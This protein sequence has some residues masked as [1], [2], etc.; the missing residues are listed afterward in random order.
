MKKTLSNLFT[1]P[2]IPSIAGHRFKL[3]NIESDRVMIALLIFQWFI[4]TF[5]TSI[6][7]DT[8]Y[9][10][11]FGSALIVLPIIFLYPYLKGQRYYRYFIAIAMMLFS[12]IFIQQ[13]LG[14]IEMHFHIFIA[15]A[16]LTLYKDVMPLI[17]AA[18]TTI[19]HHIVFNYLQFYE[20]SLFDMPVMVFNYG[21]GF[22]IVI[23]HAIFVISELL[24]LGYITK[25]QIERTII[26][27]NTEYQVTE[28]NKELQHTIMA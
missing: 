9:Y 13:Y 28:L 6:L 11:F 23:L 26:L 21:C 10:G 7:Y 5:V 18:A 1:F 3:F 19:L 15:M 25:L 22:D 16:I 24:V 17:I 2:N 14:R 27:H 20:V 4:A 12:V 8:Y